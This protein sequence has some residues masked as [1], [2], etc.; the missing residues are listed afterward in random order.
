M[1]V[2]NVATSEIDIVINKYD[3]SSHV[4]VGGYQVS[5]HWLVNENEIENISFSIFKLESFPY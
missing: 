5:S 1:E 2:C 4:Y 3:V